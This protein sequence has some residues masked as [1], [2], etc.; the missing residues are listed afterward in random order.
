[1]I[2]GFVFFFLP[3]YLYSPNSIVSYF[4]S[5]NSLYSFFPLLLP[6][7]GLFN[8]QLNAIEYDLSSKRQDHIYLPQVVPVS[9]ISPLK[10][11]FFSFYL[12]SL[13]HGCP[14]NLVGIRHQI[15]GL[16]NHF[17]FQLYQKIE[18]SILY[19]TSESRSGS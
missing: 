16:F 8:R 5:S 12:E 18:Y 9:D 2:L 7:V 19:R 4:V 6:P 3:I 11:F 17:V 13:V 10:I 14:H 15:Q 1:M